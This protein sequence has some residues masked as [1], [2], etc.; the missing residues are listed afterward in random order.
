MKISQHLWV[1][2]IKFG[3]KHYCI[4]KIT[5]VSSPKQAH[6]TTKI[7][8]NNDFQINKISLQFFKKY[9]FVFQENQLL[10]VMWPIAMVKPL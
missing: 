4:L 5:L 7:V 8:Q 3:S 1:W 2:C 9:L 6:Q 10:A